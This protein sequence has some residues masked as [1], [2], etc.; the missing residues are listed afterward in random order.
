MAAKAEG[1]PR[2][3]RS[4]AA[5][6]PETYLHDLNPAQREAVLHTEG[7]VLV[8][9]GAGSGKTR[10]LTRRIAHLLRAVGVKPPE[11]LA[12]TFTNKAAAEMRERVEHLVGP[13]AR[14]A[15]VMTFHSACGRILRREAERLGYRSNF[16]IYDQADQVRLTKQCLEELERDPKRFTP[17]GIHSQI[18]NAKNQL[19]GPDEYAERV[20][21]FYDQTV[22]EVY[23]LYQKRMHASNAVDFDDMLYLTVEALERFPD[24]RA[25]WQKAFRY[26]LVDEYQDTNHAQYRLLQLLTEQHKNVFVVADPDQSIYAFRGADIRNVLE[27]ER[28]FPGADTIV[29][30]QNYRSTQNILDAAN[31]VI[32]NNRERKEKNLWSDL[33]EGDPV[34]VVEVE[35]EHAEARYV[36]AEIARLVEEGYSGS[37]VAVFYRTNAQSRVLEDVLVRQGIA[38]QVIGGP[39]FYERAEVKDLVAYLQVLDNPYD[40]VSLLRIANRP[41]RG[42]GDTTLARLGTWADQREISLWEAF[43]EAETAGVGSAPQKA[44][45]AFRQAIEALMDDAKQLSVPELIE[46][47]LDRS[48]YR[49]SLEAERTIEAQGRLEN[50]EEL[51]SVAREWLEQ[52]QEPSLSGFLQ[53]ISLYS[54]QDAIRGEGSLVTLMTIHNAKGLEFRAVYLIGMEE[55]IFPHSRSIEEQGIEEERRLCYVGMTRAMERLTLLHASTRML[56]GGRDHNLPSR[57]LDEVPERHV[58]RDRLRPASWSGY[59]V[60]QQSQVAPRDDVPSL[61]TGD[62]VRHS[63][64]GEGV[65]IRIEPGGVVT[66][67]FAGDDSERRLMLDYAPLEKI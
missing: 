30:D 38:Y 47:V 23:S 6:T 27:F 62:S 54:D 66:V 49:E 4:M 16:T 19:V 15:W 13:P 10:V 51:V 61:S 36:A 56:Y 8:I 12:I 28:D 52:S 64:L 17:R 2:Y 9:A 65:V 53:E 5:T 24:A 37:E 31:G 34:R 41:R 29:L 44:V 32:R 57:F 25:K 63:T 40:A 21:S 11:I 22:A 1:V 55:G 46:A 35:D 50:L 60:P 3:D 42:I 39:R 26:V 45:R 48:G 59:G 7:P 33:G 43:A 20:A 67:R 14:A 18:S 58:E